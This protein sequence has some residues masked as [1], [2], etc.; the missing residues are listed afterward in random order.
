MKQRLFNSCVK[1][2]KVYSPQNFIGILTG[3]FYLFSSSSFIRGHL[4]SILEEHGYAGPISFDIDEI[5]II[6]NGN[7]PVVLVDTS[8]YQSNGVYQNNFTWFRVP[9]NFD[10]L[11]AE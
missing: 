9:E 10:A 4:E 8:F 1:S 11:V 5:E 7:Y 6:V 2:Q 3:N